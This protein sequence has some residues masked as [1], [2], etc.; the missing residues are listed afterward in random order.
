MLQLQ[1]PASSGT[2]LRSPPHDVAMAVLWLP[3]AAAEYATTEH[4][5]SVLEDAAER[6]SSR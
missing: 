2:W 6:G 5:P 1:K 4:E 3:F